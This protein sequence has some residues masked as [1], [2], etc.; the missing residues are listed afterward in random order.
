[1][2]NSEILEIVKKLKVKENIF[3]SS[4]KMEE[5]LGE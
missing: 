1:M 5:V 2:K 3:D 4:F